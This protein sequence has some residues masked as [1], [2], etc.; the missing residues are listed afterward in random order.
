MIA[1][2]GWKF[3]GRCGWEK[4][5]DYGRDCLSVMTHQIVLKVKSK[6]NHDKNFDAVLKEIEQNSH[7]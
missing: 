7:T 5:G 1:G 3:V 2:T 4:E 6:N